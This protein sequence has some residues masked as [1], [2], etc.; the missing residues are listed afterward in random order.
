MKTTFRKK[1]LI[2]TLIIFI[3]SNLYFSFSMIYASVTYTFDDTEFYNTMANSYSNFIE[4]KND[5][6]KTIQF[7][8]VFLA[9]NALSI[10]NPTLTNISDI[11]KF[12]HLEKVNLSENVG[13]TD[14]SPLATLPNLKHLELYN[15]NT[16]DLN[17]LSNISSLEHLVL[18]NSNVTNV[19]DLATLS[20]LNWL[21]LRS[22]NLT[23]NDITSLS[24]LTNLKNLAISDNNITNISAL[25]SL[26]SLVHLEAI[27]NQISDV[28]PLA[29]L[30][31]LEIAYLYNNNISDI[32]SLNNLAN[33]QIL[34]LTNNNISDI[35]KVFAPSG[36]LSS[37][38]TLS[39]SGNKLTNVDNL[40]ALV[41]NQ[42][43]PTNASISLTGNSITDLSGVSGIDTSKYR[44]T[45]NSQKITILTNKLTG[46]KLPSYISEVNQIGSQ[47]YISNTPISTQ[48]CTLSADNTTLDIHPGHTTATLIL[49]SNSS[50]VTLGSS[51][52]T[53][54]TDLV[55]PKLTYNNTPN[56]ATT[57]NVLV[58]ITADEQIQELVG[59]TLSPDKLS[60][61][62]TYS[63]NI[64]EN[65][66]VTDLAGNESTIQIIVDNIQKTTP[67]TSTGNN[68]SSNNTVTGSTTNSD[69]TTTSSNTISQGSNPTTGDNILLYIV[70]V[71][72][73][74]FG[75]TSIIIS[76]KVKKN[77]K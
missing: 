20:N 48:N 18:D 40:N 61:T 45:T 77:I 38:T 34:E 21:D 58:T 13:I 56:T 66:T 22:N 73:S 62:K 16:I 24:S 76:K 70:L 52:I 17:Q 39:L 42:N 47:Y 25:S 4:S 23:S 72:I 14:F 60:L 41:Q 33:L 36:N 28:N 64:T 9:I 75:L 2:M 54:I 57:Q 31:N 1:F 26:S 35:S 10:R 29:N 7:E 46:I 67:D 53:I 43:L 8:D 71:S 50:N 30:T 49:P 59:W 37:L 11:S 5:S 12:Q 44:I 3:I 63:S 55:A 27:S 69:N 68:T 6:T 19:S 74:I 51:T 65:I 32:T 15:L